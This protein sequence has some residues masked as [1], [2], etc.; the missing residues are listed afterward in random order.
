M[1]DSL[2]KLVNQANAGYINRI[3]FNESLRGATINV[4]ASPAA[5]D[6]ANILWNS[7]NRDWTYLP[8]QPSVLPDGTLEETIPYGPTAYR[9]R[10]NLQIDGGSLGITLKGDAGTRAFYVRKDASFSLAN[11]TLANFAAL[12]SNGQNGVSGLANQATGGAGGGA[13][14]G[15]AILN[16]GDTTIQNVLF[17]DNNAI[18]GQGGDALQPAPSTYLRRPTVAGE[19][20][21]SD[22]GFTGQGGV[23][24]GKMAG[25]SGKPVP[26]TLTFNTLE[27][28]TPRTITV[29]LAA[30][31]GGGSGQGGAIYNAA[32]ASLK[33]T[34]NT[35]FKNNSASGGQGGLGS[36]DF[37]TNLANRIFGDQAHTLAVKGFGLADLTSATDGAGL[38]QNIFNDDGRVSVD[39]EAIHQLGAPAGISLSN[40]EIAENRPAGTVVGKFSTS[41]AGS[42]QQMKYELVSGAGSFDNA[43]FTITNGQLV[44]NRSFNYE[45]QNAYS[46]RVR[47]TDANGLYTEQVFVISVAD[48]KESLKPRI[49]LPKQFSTTADAAS[50]LIFTN[51]PFADLVAKSSQ[52]FTVSLRVRVGSLSAVS[53]ANV[54]VSGVSTNLTFKGTISALNAYFTSPEGRIRYTPVAH[55][56]QSRV[57]QVRIS[58]L[59]GFNAISSSAF[60]KIIISALRNTRVSP[61]RPARASNTHIT[62][63]SMRQSADSG[64]IVKP[65]GNH[66]PRF[67]K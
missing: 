59:N 39:P 43:S 45:L 20:N 51:A 34:G 8:D 5:I 38:G 46:V 6:P 35:A 60:G 29:M 12:G 42:V 36:P 22:G 57:I 27:D 58:K 24:G 44:A 65:R 28:A 32:G 41:N 62:A 54:S 25:I 66:L 47:V 15:G 52:L 56:T 11:L 64:T 31:G 10:K 33:I 61:I 7:V 4:T 3:I 53:T 67:I 14:L 26:V 63:E 55:S 50:S 1:H 19:P 30:A 37:I 13:G 2:L 40:L 48:R 49:S 18:G 21:G 23:G 17:K 9:V 16:F